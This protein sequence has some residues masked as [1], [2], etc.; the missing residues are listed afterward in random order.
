MVGRLVEYQQVG[1]GD[2][3]VCQCHTLLLSAAQLSHGLVE[4]AYLQLGEHL[5][6]LEHLL[7]LALV[8]EARLKHCLVGVEHRRLFEYAHLYVLAEYYTA[9]IGRVDACK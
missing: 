2:E 1:L 5:F 7:V 8:V 9:R 3:H 6:C 4:V